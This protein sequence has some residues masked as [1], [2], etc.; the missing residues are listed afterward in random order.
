MD[1]QRFTVATDDSDRRL[2]RIVRRLLP[3][4]P[5]SRI[6]QLMRKGLIKLDGKKADPAIHPREGC[7]IWIASPVWESGGLMDASPGKDEVM[8]AFTPEILFRN[9]DLLFIN[10]PRGMAT[11]GEGG[12]D[13]V[14]TPLLETSES[15]S[16][17]P[18][19]LHRLD[20]GT[21]GLLAFSRSLAGAQWFSESIRRHDIRKYYLGIVDGALTGETAWI[22]V[23]E[24]GKRM[25][26]VATPIVQSAE[27]TARYTLIR[28]R[29][30]TGRKH[31]I[32]IQS[33]AHGFPLSG[34]SKYGSARKEDGSYFL[35]ARRIVFPETRL[36]GLPDEL[37]APLPERFS[38]KVAR[39]F[40][41]ET[42]A[43]LDRG[44]VYWKDHDEH[45]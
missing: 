8:P 18:G 27:G 21:T 11:H 10:K 3:E 37:Y 28:F 1:F 42:L 16:F 34:D 36:P 15:L 9:A 43:E 6:Y 24:E 40:G 35:H 22:D 23:D 33:S 41:T 44:A 39:V 38:L 29:I 13:R 5:L 7:E 19:P 4:M 20:K 31:Q 17:R 26:T 12:L 2:D 14:M 32:R 25:E 30:V 45:Q